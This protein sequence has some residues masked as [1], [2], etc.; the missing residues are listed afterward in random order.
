MYIFLFQIVSHFGILPHNWNR[1]AYSE[2][3]ANGWSWQH[4]KEG[5]EQRVRKKS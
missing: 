1:Q 3:K 4:D 2:E 5:T